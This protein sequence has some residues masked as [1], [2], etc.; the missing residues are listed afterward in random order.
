MRRFTVAEANALIPTLTPLLEEMHDRAI[1]LEEALEVV[2]A[3]ER[4]VA[5]NGHARD[6][7]ILEPGVDVVALR[8]A[9]RALF[10]RLTDLGVVLKDL[11]IG[12]VD[13]P[14]LRDG[15]EVYLCW[16]VGEDEVGFWH[17]TDEG[18]RHRRPL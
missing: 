4:H 14:A 8:T 2:R 15:R 11:Q 18:Y 3:F 9:L 6:A 16:H 13:F 1:Q 10:T 7:R 17:G 5:G 12:L